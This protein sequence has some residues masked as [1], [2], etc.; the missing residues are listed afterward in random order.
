MRLQRESKSEEYRPGMKAISIFAAFLAYRRMYRWGI[1]RSGCILQSM[2]IYRI[3]RRRTWYKWRKNTR[4]FS[5]RLQNLPR[6]PFIWKNKKGYRNISIKSGSRH[7]ADAFEPGP[8]ERNHQIKDAEAL[9]AAV[10]LRGWLSLKRAVGKGG[11]D[12]IQ[13]YLFRKQEKS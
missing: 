2:R 10:V 9:S 7:H 4:R 5:T 8:A 1:G 12:S 11:D 3:I 13:G 6:S